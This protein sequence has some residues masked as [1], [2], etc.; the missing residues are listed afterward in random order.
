MTSAMASLLYAV[1]VGKD[2]AQTLQRDLPQ[3]IAP[4][5]TRADAGYDRAVVAAGE[6]QRDRE[7]GR[8]DIGGA[9][10]TSQLRQRNRP[11]AACSIQVAIDAISAWAWGSPAS[12]ANSNLAQPDSGMIQV[13]HTPLQAWAKRSTFFCQRRRSRG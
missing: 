1:G 2:R 3:I 10:M 13:S 7:G 6:R 11:L 8:L 5:A 4:G 12:A 9:N